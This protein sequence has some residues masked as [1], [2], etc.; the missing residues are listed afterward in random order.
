MGFLIFSGINEINQHAYSLGHL[1]NESID[2]MNAYNTNLK[3]MNQ[4]KIDEAMDIDYQNDVDVSGFD[5]FF[6]EFQFFKRTF[7]A[8]REGVYLFVNIPNMLLVSLPF[9]SANDVDIYTNVLGFL[10]AI[11]IGIS[12]YKGITT[13]E[14][15]G[16]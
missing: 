6:K 3:P 8:F 16:R 13:K 5:A 14:V 11:M 10:I 2:A 4:T 1:D 12:I 15:D 9:I 7:D